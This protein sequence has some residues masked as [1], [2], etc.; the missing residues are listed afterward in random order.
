M[1][2]YARLNAF[3]DTLAA[4]PKQLLLWVFLP[5]FA[6]RLFT[7]LFNIG[8]FAVDDYNL[9]A[10][11]IPVQLKLSLTTSFGALI[12]VD[13]IRSPAPQ[14][15]IYVPAR[16][17]YEL[18]GVDP[19]VQV[20]AVFVV[21]GLLSMVSLYFGYR[22]FRE[23]GRP[24]EGVIA[25]ILIGF[26]FFMPFF[27]TRSMIE[28]MAAPFVLMALF[29]LVRYHR[30]GSLSA[31]ALSMILLSVA[32]M[33]RFQAGVLAV[34]YPVFIY[35]RRDWK[36]LWLT[37]V[38][39]VAG[40]ILTGLPDLIYR[41]VFHGGLIE[42]ID[43]NIKYS[44]NHGVSTPL[45][46]VA[47]LIGAILPPA[48]ISRYRGFAWRENFGALTPVWLGLA[49]FFVSHALVPH[50][51]ERFMV[52]ILPAF[53]ALL[54]PLAAFLLQRGGRLPVVLFYFI[55]NVVVTIMLALFTFQNNIIG[56]VRYLEAH[57]NVNKVVVFEHM[58]THF[59][60]AYARRKSGVESFRVSSRY[61]PPLELS[62]DCG[63]IL[64]IRK[65]YIEHA[66]LQL[67]GLSQ[68]AA[69]RA[70]PLE[71]VSVALNPSDRRRQS[72]HIFAPPD[73]APLLK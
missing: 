3:I 60:Y 4:S 1:P 43:Y 50:K 15:L 47:V 44:S 23:L 10:N 11:A 5:A 32:A 2:L 20:R 27:S 57:P 37:G 68:V 8:Y 7:A 33:L 42:Y 71:Q 26:H 24:R 25:A 38:A 46:Y 70:S 45:T 55:V 48:F 40:L 6:L 16:I 62:K 35:M 36:A 54:A 30:T 51:E 52:P 56:L 63:E 12:T 18:G 66:G 13:P 29:Y 17:A 31:I 14:A 39:G 59:P 53:L 28:G 49:V 34:I 58:I 67:A 61:T 69:F 41:G 73:C 19:L 21:M 64:I 72:Y 65:D 9:L 22:L